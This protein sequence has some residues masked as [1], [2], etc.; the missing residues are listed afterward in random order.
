MKTNINL[1]ISLEL[2]SVWEISVGLKGSFV[3]NWGLGETVFISSIVSVS[4][5]KPK[6]LKRLCMR[7]LSVF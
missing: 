6:K 5:I 1:L 4:E 2:A 7:R 3:S